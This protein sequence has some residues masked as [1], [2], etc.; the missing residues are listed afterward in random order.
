MSADMVK[1]EEEWNAEQDARTL[2]DSEAIMAD[3]GRFRK[4]QEKVRG[5]QA[6]ME[7]KAEAARKIAGAKMLYTKTPS[8]VHPKE[9]IPPPEGGGL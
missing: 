6:E 9:P 3:E 5:M 8:M 1:T 7:A 4:A 2:L